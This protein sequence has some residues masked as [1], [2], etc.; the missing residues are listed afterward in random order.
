MEMEELGQLA[1]LL[2]AISKNK[3]VQMEIVCRRYEEEWKFSLNSRGTLACEGLQADW[4]RGSQIKEKSGFSSSFSR[5]AALLTGLE[6]SSL[7]KGLWFTPQ[8]KLTVI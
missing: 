4:G 1:A 6:N 5:H 3:A 7:F 8:H 2:L